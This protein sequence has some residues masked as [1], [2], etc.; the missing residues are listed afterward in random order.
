MS[1]SPT[2]VPP[3]KSLFFAF[4]LD[5]FL[6]FFF[7]LSFSLSVVSFTSPWMRGE[8]HNQWLCFSEMLQ[9]LGIAVSRSKARDCCEQIS[10]GL[11]RRHEAIRHQATS[12]LNGLGFGVSALL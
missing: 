7:L 11:I 5:F 3:G 12:L 2:Q 9:R 4:F 1:N 6:S 8:T 10:V